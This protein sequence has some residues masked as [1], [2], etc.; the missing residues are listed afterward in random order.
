MGGIESVISVIDEPL[1]GY[2]PLY[3][4]ILTLER[5]NTQ[6]DIARRAV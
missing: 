4:E 5:W 3:D 2:H 1:L 6:G